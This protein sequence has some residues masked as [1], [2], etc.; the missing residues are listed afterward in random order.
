MQNSNKSSL[1]F[2]V[3]AIILILGGVFYLNRRMT[4]PEKKQETAQAPAPKKE[5]TKK[6]SDS[7]SSTGTSTSPSTI[8]KGST[9]N[10]TASSS[11]TTSSST[12]APSSTATTSATNSTASSTASTT[13]TSSSSTSSTTSGTTTAQSTTS[14]QTTAPASPA[15]S[16]QNLSATQFSAKYVSYDGQKG[17]YEITG[18]GIQNASVCRPGVKLQLYS[19]E[20]FSPQI[21]K[22]YVISA[23][24]L[25]EVD[26]R[27]QI[28]D[29]QKVEPIN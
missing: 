19:L 8:L 1:F 23:S 25:Q 24:N 10:T 27:I 2:A 13:G 26:G 20:K 5:T 4:Q 11:E 6:V 7:S 12:S 29:I 22:D 14:N 3:L 21:G 28:S 17:F 18:C 16:P 9:E 15:P